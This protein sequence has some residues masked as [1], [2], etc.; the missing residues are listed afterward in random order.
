MW[1]R[2]PMKVARATPRRL[3]LEVTRLSPSARRE[4]REFLRELKTVPRPVP[5]AW[6][7]PRLLPLLAGP[8]F[9]QPGETL[10]RTVS[11]LGP[12]VEF[13]LTI[14]RRFARVDAAV[15][16]RWE[17][18]LEQL[19][20]RAMTNLREQAA[21]LHPGSVRTGVMSGREVR[22]LDGEPPWATS[23]LLDQEALQRVFGPH[24]QLLAACRTDCLLSMTT[25]TPV[26]VFGE[27]A[28]DLERE[29]DSLWLD[30]FVLE[31]G[32]LRWVGSRLDDDD[33]D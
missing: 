3:V 32:E 20:D 5:W 16:E 19:L 4:Q 18:S 7:A 31:S 24:D 17:C 13:G 11:A 28:V 6:A 8:R 30:P 25:A 14:A 1:H 33:E 12:V 27:I 26:S 23:L 21:M 10:V 2:V 29:E 15:A 22:T 9:D